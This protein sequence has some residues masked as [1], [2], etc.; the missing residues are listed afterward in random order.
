[1]KHVHKSFDEIRF[2]GV[3]GLI[4]VMLAFYLVF[5]GMI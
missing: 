2:Y 4:V 5:G 3:F 1:M